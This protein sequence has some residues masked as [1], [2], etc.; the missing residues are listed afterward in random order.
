MKAGFSPQLTIEA[1]MLKRNAFHGLT[2]NK[3]NE[4]LYVKLGG[5][6][7]GEERPVRDIRNPFDPDDLAELHFS[8]MVKLIDEHW[9]GKRP[10][11][12]RPYPEFMKDYGRY[13][14]LARVREW[15]LTGG[16]AEDGGE[17]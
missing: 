6:N 4:L 14:H 13:D 15:S 12:S 16:S 11:L 2:G 5:K 7:G 10:F 8:E 3:T 1:A 9:N 17:E